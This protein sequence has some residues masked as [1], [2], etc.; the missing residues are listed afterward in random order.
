M[1]DLVRVEFIGCATAKLPNDIDVEVGGE[2]VTI[3][4][5]P[6][7]AWEGRVRDSFNPARTTLTVNRLNARTTCH[8]TGRAQRIDR[9][10]SC[11]VDFSVDCEP[12]WSLHVTNTLK[13]KETPMSYRWDSDM[14]AL[15]WCADPP[16]GDVLLPPDSPRTI[17]SV[18]VSQGVILGLRAADGMAIEYAIKEPALHQFVKKVKLSE[19]TPRPAVRSAAGSN[20]FLTAL[21]RQQALAFEHIVL[22]WD[23][24]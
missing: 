23:T 21:K 6:D 15:P 16:P 13:K 20:A 8:I 22:T 17:P 19:L 3:R 9:G 11:R 4:K 5:Q 7:G 12:L 24:P 10:E 1:C 14:N 2:S 18:G